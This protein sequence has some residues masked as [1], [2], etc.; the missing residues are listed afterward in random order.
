MHEVEPLLGLEACL[1][2][3][4]DPPLLHQHTNVAKLLHMVEARKASYHLLGT[5]PLKGL[6]VKVPEALMPLPRLVIPTSSETEGLCR[7]SRS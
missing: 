7:T 1:L 4:G 3:K 5:E 2:G 6:E